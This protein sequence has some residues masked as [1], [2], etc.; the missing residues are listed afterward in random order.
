MPLKIYGP[1]LLFP[2]EKYFSVSLPSQIHIW[3]PFSHTVPVVPWRLGGNPGDVLVTGKVLLLFQ[4]L[5][6]FGQ[7]NLWKIPVNMQRLLACYTLTAW[8]S[9]DPVWTY[10]RPGWAGL[11]LI[12]L[13]GW[14]GQSWMWSWARKPTARKQPHTSSHGYN[15]RLASKGKVT[16]FLTIN[17]K[18]E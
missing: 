7:I 3:S 10:F 11:S 18:V 14:S 6:R 17:R 1:L 4:C 15:W 8:F 16:G 13:L 2:K 9:E 12:Q 5:F